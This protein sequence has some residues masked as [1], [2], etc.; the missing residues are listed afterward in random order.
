MEGEVADS[1]SQTERMTGPR[2]IHGSFDSVE[3]CKGSYTW[4]NA[5]CVTVNLNALGVLGNIP[6]FRWATFQRHSSNLQDKPMSNLTMVEVKRNSW[7]LCLFWFDFASF[8]MFGA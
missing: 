5:T 7:Q 2:R 6:H 1:N 3:Q 4:L 8:S